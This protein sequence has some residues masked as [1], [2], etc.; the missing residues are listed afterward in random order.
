MYAVRGYIKYKDLNGYDKILYTDLYATRDVN[1]AE[2]ILRDAAAGKTTITDTEKAYYENIISTSKAI[3]AEDFSGEHIS[4]GGDPNDENSFK[5]VYEIQGNGLQV[6]EVNIYPNDYVEGETEREP[7]V[8]VQ[9]SDLHFNYVSE[10]DFKEAN[11]SIMSTYKGRTAFRNTVPAAVNALRYAYTADAMVTTGDVIDFLSLGS[12]ELTKKYLFDT[13]PYMLASLGNHEGTRVCQQPEGEKAPDPTTLE[14]RHEILQTIWNSDIFYSSQL[15]GDRVLLIQLEDGTASKFWDVQVEP[16][17]A[18][19]ELAREK[20]Y[21]V[22]LFF[23]IPLRTYNPN[24]TAVDQ[25]E[26]TTSRSDNSGVR[27]FTTEGIGRATDA[28]KAIFGLIAENSDIIK[29]M[30][31]GHT[32]RPYYSEFAAEIDE[33]GVVTKVVPQYTMTATAYGKGSATKIII[34]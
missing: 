6:R 10:E 11:P 18:D 16:F 7:L 28:S 19:L 8:V 15:V 27:N 13:Y 33:N 31:T 23:H 34:H 9:T 22:L 25:L 29:G 12:M 17:K 30:F 4:V 21:T 14:S 1:I 2:T 3:I 26:N 32:H 24:E 20:G 5:H